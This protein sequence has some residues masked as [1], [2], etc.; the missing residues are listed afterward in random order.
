MIAQPR[1][2]SGKINAICRTSRESR[3]NG[4]GLGEVWVDVDGW[5]ERGGGAG[6]PENIFQLR[7]W[8]LLLLDRG[9]LQLLSSFPDFVVGLSSSLTRIKDTQNFANKTN[10]KLSTYS[11]L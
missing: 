9:V 5:G 10:M 2:E 8:H 7:R 3:G 6:W 11:T 1:T 4:G